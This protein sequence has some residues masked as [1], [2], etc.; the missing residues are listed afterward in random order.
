[1]PTTDSGSSSAPAVWP[2]NFRIRNHAS[3]MVHISRT[4]TDPLVINYPRDKEKYNDQYFSFLRE[5]ANFDRIEYHVD[6]AKILSSAVVAMGS[7]TDLPNTYSSSSMH[8]TSDG[9]TFSGNVTTTA[10]PHAQV[11]ATAN[12]TRSAVS[13]PFTMYVTVAS[14]NTSVAIEGTHNG[15]SFENL[16]ADFKQESIPDNS[17]KAPCAY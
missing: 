7:A 8:T 5:L 11:T 16:K 14:D 10:S 17:Q 2:T 15:T 3:D 4:T 1:M 12:M 13:V 9:T 6:K